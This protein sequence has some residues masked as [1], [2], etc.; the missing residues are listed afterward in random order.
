MPLLRPGVPAPPVHAPRRGQHPRRARHPQRRFQRAV[1]W[2]WITV[3]PIDQT[4]PP[5]TPRPNP[6]PPT[7]DEAALIVTEA[8]KDPQWGLFVWMTLTPGARR[9]EMC[10]LRW[11]RLDLTSGVPVFRRRSA[12]R[13]GRRT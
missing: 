6:D 7:P 10:N 2:G 4:E 9:G 13:S 11:N 12:G 3:S 1:R 5:P 8:W